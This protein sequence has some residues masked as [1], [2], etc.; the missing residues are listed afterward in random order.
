TAEALE[1]YQRTRRA[2][3]AELGIE[4]SDRLQKLE[5]AILTADPALGPSAEPVT[6]QPV[7]RQVPS[8]LPT[9]IADFTGRTEQIG[10]IRE[11]VVHAAGQEARVA[12]PV[13]VIVGKGGV[14]K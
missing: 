10:Q 14:G 4:P 9:D 3:I 5:H 8:L 2:M 11:H 7:N 13:V 12:V 1:V 6:A